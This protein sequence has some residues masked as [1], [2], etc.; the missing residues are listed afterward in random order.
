MQP[1]SVLKFVAQ[2]QQSRQT[3]QPAS[4]QELKVRVPRTALHQSNFLAKYDQKRVGCAPEDALGDE[5]G[6][7][8]V[9]QPRQRLNRAPALHGDVFDT[10]IEALDDS[11][12]TSLV[13]VAFPRQSPNGGPP[14]GPVAQDGRV[15]IECE[16]T[17][18][19]HQLLP[20]LHKPDVESRE[21][22]TEAYTSSSSE[23]EPQQA[24]SLSDRSDH[25][26]QDGL[27]RMLRSSSLPGPAAM[28]INSRPVPM[29]H[30][31]KILQSD[32][33]ALTTF[34]DSRSM[35]PKHDMATTDHKHQISLKS[36]SRNGNYQFDPLAPGGHGLIRDGP[37]VHEYSSNGQANSVSSSACSASGELA[38][39][40]EQVGRFN[41]AADRTSL[42]SSRFGSPEQ[43][44]LLK[45]Q[46]TEV[47]AY[48]KQSRELDYTW[49]DLSRMSYS[50]LKGESFDLIPGVVAGP[51]ELLSAAELVD[52]LKQ[53]L[54]HQR[55]GQEGKKGRAFFA[56][57]S[58]DQYEECGDLIIEGFKDILGKFK[59][60]RQ[61]KRSLTQKFEEQVHRRQHII[62]AKQNSI[63]KDLKTMRH[64]GSGLI[65]RSHSQKLDQG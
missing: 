2:R 48:V 1:E 53:I 65:P 35:V 61:Q 22:D 33:A 17:R 46:Q 29:Q 13:D 15:M 39:Q 54:S 63:E 16:R 20:H 45:T 50:R 18:R 43:A 14:S 30:S 31:R 64:N 8:S 44:E 6:R 62:G 12:T 9:N 10:D 36:S 47:Q 34:Q 3:D 27:S 7:P 26:S 52:S 5:V 32:G 28:F 11:L 24:S 60:A 25:E 21:A 56:T 41:L 37:S 51:A 4:A 42:Q 40:E 55:H 49:D 19:M 57:L 23:G 38:G 58:I 59:D